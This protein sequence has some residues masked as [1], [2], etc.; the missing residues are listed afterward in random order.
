M[1][2]QDKLAINGGE[3][4]R[5]TPFPASYP[6]ASVYGEEEKKAVM[7]VI[8]SKSPF[9]YYGSNVLGKAKEFENALSQKLGNKYTL[10]VTSGTAA[11]VVALKAAGIG[12]GDKVIVPACTFLATPGAVI[13]A[14]AV[15]IFADIDESM[16]IDPE[17]ISKVVDKYTKAIIP[18]PILGN[19]CQ[20]DRVMQAAKKHNLIVIEDVAQSC[21]SK[22]NGQYSGTFGNINCFSLQMN[23]I[24]TTGDGGAVSTND[25]KLYER[26]VRYHDQGMFREK[27]GFLSKSPADDVFIG[28]NYR[29]SEV[30]G[31]IALAQVKKLD[32]IIESMRKAKYTIKEQIKDIKGLEFRRI[33]DE[34]GD[35]GNALIMLL[36]NAEINKEFRHALNEEGIET[37]M[38]YNGEP[39]YMLPQIF[40]KKTA[41]NSGFPFNQFNEEIVYARDMCPAS[42]DIMSRNALIGL[43]PT[44]NEQDVED[45]VKAIRKVASYIL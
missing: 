42:W 36:P 40:N 25:S 45:I 24:I 29:M 34:A 33:N 8:D 38:L 32:F 14:G 41:E 16:S 4:V 30:S 10:G 17:S 20:M 7:E 13:C 1:P 22:F 3:P 23:K 5:N 11:L 21:G 2:N 6:G 37:G 31:A 19:P 39:I 28:Q 26:A 43:S 35:A 18:V 9:R 44:F 15:P 27:E 12:P